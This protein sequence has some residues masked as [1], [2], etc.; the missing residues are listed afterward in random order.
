MGLQV[1][2]DDAS[3]HGRPVKICSLL[4]S[5]TEIVYALGFGD[6]LVGVT[7][8]CDFPEE[9]RSKPVV[10][11]SLIDTSQASSAEVEAR[12]QALLAAGRSPYQLD[13]EA[14]RDARPDIVLTQDVC[15]RCDVSERDV[16]SVVAEFEPAPVVLVLNPRT[17]NEIFDT[18]R[19]VAEAVGD[20]GAGDKLL[21][22]MHSRLARVSSTTSAIAHYP[23]VASLEGIDP[24][25]A[26]GHWLP[27]VK[28][29][30]GGRD[31]LFTPGCAAER[32]EWKV[33]REYDPEVL[34][35]TPCSSGTS[36]SLAE[37][38][39]LA[40]QEGWWQMH[41]VR[42]G[43]VYV[44]DHVYF[45]RPGPRIVQGVEILAQIL[46]PDIFDGMIPPGTALKLHRPLCGN[47]APEALAHCFVDHPPPRGRE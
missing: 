30:A 28:V 33:L 46:H 5:G 38:E 6:S 45:S 35:I 16:N 3:R 25:V 26:G 1:M 41:A 11:H 27:E 39:I 7:E 40:R 29:L 47:V 36:R 14:L 42:S 37:I 23:T 4:P 31:G 13:V 32:I 21:Q 34:I 43:A 18:V 19:A 9:A 2:V 8:L 44:I 10:S 24:L 20:P 12:M 17:L 22:E 15:F